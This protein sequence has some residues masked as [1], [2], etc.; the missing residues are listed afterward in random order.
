MKRLRIPLL[1]DLLRPILDDFP[2][3]ANRNRIENMVR[4]AQP[5]INSIRKVAR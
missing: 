5:V 3:I 2:L 1:N 4:D